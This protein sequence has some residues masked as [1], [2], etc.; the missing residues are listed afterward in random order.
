MQQNGLTSESSI[1]SILNVLGQYVYDN[2]EYVAD[3]EDVWQSV[4]QTLAKKAGDCEDINLVLRAMVHAGLRKSGKLAEVDKV[5]LS[6]GY[7][8]LDERGIFAY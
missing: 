1:E 3:V 2:F 5:V 6:L 7:L 8:R 4:D